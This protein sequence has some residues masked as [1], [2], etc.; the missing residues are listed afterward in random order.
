MPSTGCRCYVGTWERFLDSP[1]AT[2][3]DYA[4]PGSQPIGLQALRSRVATLSRRQ[5]IVLYCGCCP[6]N[7]CPN[8]GP[9]FHQLHDMGFT[10]VKVLYLADNFGADWVDRGYPVERGH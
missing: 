2:G 9:A 8:V 10:N 7:H 4:G 3:A 1:G 6:W 5:F